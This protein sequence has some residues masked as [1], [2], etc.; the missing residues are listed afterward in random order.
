MYKN[1]VKSVFIDLASGSLT[2]IINSDVVNQLKNKNSAKNC[3]F[4]AFIK[5]TKDT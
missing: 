1:V 2:I 5:N 3:F 4:F